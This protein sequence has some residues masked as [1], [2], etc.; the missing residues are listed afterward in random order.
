MALENQLP[1]KA[2]PGL[3]HFGVISP[4]V[5]EILVTFN[6]ESQGALTTVAPETVAWADVGS[7][8]TPGAFEAKVP[9][10]LPSSMA[11]NEFDGTRSYNKLDLAAPLV[12]AIP[13]DLNYEWPL[14]IDQ[15][16]I[17]QLKDFYGASGL[18][19]NMVDAARNHKAQLVASLI[20]TGFSNTVLGV[21]AKA[22]TIPQP[23]YPDGLPLFSDGA[24]EDANH[25]KHYSHPLK[26]TSGRFANMFLGAGKITDSGVFEDMIVSMSQVPHPSLPNQTLGCRVTDIIG[27]THMLMEFY[28]VAIQNLSLE[29]SGSN[30]AATTNVRN[31]A[32]IEQAM[33]SGM[34]IGASGLTP[35]RFWIAPQLDNHPYLV[36]NPGKHMWLAVSRPAGTG[37]R[38]TW[39]E[40]VAPSKEFTPRVTLFGDGVPESQRRRMVSMISDLDAGV[41]AGLPHF[42]QLRLET[43]PA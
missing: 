25:A 16:G 36:A 35:W 8:V 41:A 4:A 18:A 39:A 24:S 21:T 37:M 15:S 9:I 22:R 19:Q 5:Q 31:P 17:A 26:S 23:N 43:T 10:R 6:A 30:F 14:I 34:F 28:K 2:F 11:Y 13:W 40:L 27:P 32:M 29:V 42:V 3:T 12:K 38:D 7:R 33:K 1:L 20:Y